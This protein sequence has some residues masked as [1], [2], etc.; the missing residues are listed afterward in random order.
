MRCKPLNKQAMDKFISQECDEKGLNVYQCNE[1]KV[2]S[3]RSRKPQVC[4]LCLSTDIR[5]V[6]ERSK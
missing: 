6:K 5:V 2:V 1:C 3:S 4:G